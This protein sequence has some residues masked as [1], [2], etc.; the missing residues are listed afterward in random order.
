MLCCAVLRTPVGLLKLA[1]VHNTQACPNTFPLW[2]VASICNLNRTP[3]TVLDN[4]ILQ[5]LLEW[6]SC[7]VFTGF[8]PSVRPG[9]D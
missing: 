7:G 8:G 9:Q 3:Q 6:L 2:Q 4:T 5:Q 1:S